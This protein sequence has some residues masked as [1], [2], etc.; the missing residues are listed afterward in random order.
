MRLLSVRENQSGG[1]GLTSVADATLNGGEIG[2]NGIS[3]GE[4]SMQLLKKVEELTLYM[5]ELEKKNNEMAIE[6]EKLKKKE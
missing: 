3:V 6:I 5:I 4:M 2:K 1:L